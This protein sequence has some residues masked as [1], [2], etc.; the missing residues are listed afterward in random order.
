VIGA[1]QLDQSNHFELRER[2]ADSFEGQT[3]EISNV[4]P[5]HRQIEV[6]ATLSLLMVLRKCQQKGYDAFNSPGPAHCE[7]EIT[8]DCQISCQCLIELEADP[9]IPCC[10]LTQRRDGESAQ[11]RWLYG[12]RIHQMLIVGS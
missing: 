9:R 7:H 10:Q 12:L 1:R 6:A 5:C 4:G 3:E 2:A 11:P 8:R